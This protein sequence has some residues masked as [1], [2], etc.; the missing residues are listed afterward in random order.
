MS[1]LI[2]DRQEVFR[3]I[4]NEGDDAVQCRYSDVANWGSAY[5][6]WLDP[7]LFPRC[8]WRRTPKLI[9]RSDVLRIIAD[10]G[11]EAVQCRNTPD[12]SWRGVYWPWME[13]GTFERVQWRRT[14]KPAK[15]A[16]VA[17]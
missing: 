14:P 9:L 11:E 5:W 13:L 12:A 7:N 6:P 16:E 3:I 4:G 17:E 8:Q 10:E 1:E 2:T 15:K